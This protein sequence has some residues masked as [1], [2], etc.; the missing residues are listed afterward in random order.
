ME[1]YLHNYYN[2]AVFKVV[3]ESI[4]CVGKGYKAMPNFSKYISH[5]ARMHVAI[6]VFSTIVLS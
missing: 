5:M 2:H 3:A 6:H 1:D 4:A